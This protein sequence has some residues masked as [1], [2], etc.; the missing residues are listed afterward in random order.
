MRTAMSITT[1]NAIAMRTAM[2]ITTMNA[3]AMRMAM[4]ILQD[5]LVVIATITRRQAKQR[6]MA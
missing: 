5:V 1:M 2:S 6:N 4:S 3:I